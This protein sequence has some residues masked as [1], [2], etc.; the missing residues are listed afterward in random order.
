MARKQTHRTP[1]TEN[2]GA[3]NRGAMRRAHPGRTMTLLICPTEQPSDRPVHDQPVVERLRYLM[4]SADPSARRHYEQTAADAL[5]RIA[6]LEGDLSVAR[7]KLARIADQ[8][9]SL[10]QSM[11]DAGRVISNIRYIIN[12]TT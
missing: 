9:R 4:G 11:D 6:E 7:L 8:V 1:K 10:P 3:G 5:E 2:P 12:P